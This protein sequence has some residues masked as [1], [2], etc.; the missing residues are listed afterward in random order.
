MVDNDTLK[1]DRDKKFKGNEPIL[2]STWLL[3]YLEKYQFKV[4][5]GQYAYPFS[6]KLPQWLPASMCQTN[7]KN[8]QEFSIKYILRA[9]F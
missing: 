7:D 1:E 6:V 4:G 5:P 9:Q 8:S 3:C 2:K